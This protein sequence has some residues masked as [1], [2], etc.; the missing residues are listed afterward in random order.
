LFISRSKADE[1]A[2]IPTLTIEHPFTREE[3]KSGNK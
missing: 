2:K 1:C 3:A